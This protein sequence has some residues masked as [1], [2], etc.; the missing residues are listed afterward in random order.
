MAKFNSN[1]I[2]I[3]YD[4]TGSGRP[5]VLLH[6]F[7]ANRHN[8]WRIS[9]WY[10]ALEKAGY[11][12]IAADARGHGRSDKPTDPQDYGPQAIAGDV[13]NLLDHL[14]LEQADL[15]GYSM[16]G[17]NAA[18]LL[19]QYPQRFGAVVI[20]GTG[21]NLLNV[22]EAKD[23][24]T[25]GYRLTA[26]NKPRSSL[27][28]PGLEPFLKQ[29]VRFGG[30]PAALSACLLGAFPSMSRA[31]FDGVDTPALVICGEKDRVSGSP[32][33]L[34]ASIPN[35]RAAV[36]RGKNHMTAIADSFVKS[37]VLDFLGE[38]RKLAA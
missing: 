2:T 14:E 6:G 33:P 11:R 23:W 5:V 13:I 4:D 31:D 34:A 18:W 7:A 1:G 17:R 27:A 24:E 12:V 16:G 28:F 29:A 22:Q 25:Q 9:G 37:C 19:S 10:R 20:G 26:D 32:E 3:D 35:A 21:V 15:F 38:Q 30:R 36:A 8:N